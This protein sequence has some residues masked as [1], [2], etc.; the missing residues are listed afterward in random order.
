ML[1]EIHGVAVFLAV[2]GCIVLAGWV[3][4]QIAK[5]VQKSRRARRRQ[6]H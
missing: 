3:A 6:R 4:E 1:A 2:I 5:D